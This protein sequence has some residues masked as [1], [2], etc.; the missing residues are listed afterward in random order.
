[1]RYKT[2]MIRAIRNEEKHAETLHLRLLVIAAGSFGVLGVAVFF[3]ALQVFAMNS[4]IQM[5]RN[6]LMRIQQEYK[7]YR[8]TTEII[9]RQDIE[10]LNRLKKSSVLW[11]KKLAVIAHHLP[12]NY[13]I[14]DIQF[15]SG[16]MI[17]KGYGLLQHKQDQLIIINGYLDR[18]RADTLFND[19]FRTISLESTER[20]ADETGQEKVR[21]EFSAKAPRLTKVQPE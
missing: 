18:L 3:L 15:G 10:Q 19:L 1:M 12:E 14:T 11:T 7:G 16:A 21:F 20:I 2:S 13:W 17:V 4:V 8:A 9:E 5:E 6:D